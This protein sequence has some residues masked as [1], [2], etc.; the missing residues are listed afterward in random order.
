MLMENIISVIVV[1]YNQQDTI[2]AT[3]DSILQQ[4]CH[5]PVEIV[6]GDDCST[7]ETGKICQQYA[8][9]HPQS[10]RYIRNAKN[11]G[12]VNNYF[13]CLLACRGAYIADCAGDDHWTDCH[14]LEAELTLLEAHPD[15]TLV[16]TNWQYYSADTG[17]MHPSGTAP[18]TARIT[19]GERMI[20]PIL[21]AT[22]R[23][24]IHLCTALYRKAVFMQAYQDDEGLF[25]N[26]NFT[27]ED[28]QI[29]FV[30]ARQGN[31]AYLPQCTLAY[32]LSPHTISNAYDEEKSFRFVYGVTQLLDYIAQ[33]YDIH[34][35]ALQRTLRNKM[36]ALAMHAFRASSP[37][38]IASL[39]QL[40]THHHLPTDLRYHIV[41]AVTSYRWS[42]RCALTL[43][44]LYLKIK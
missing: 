8:R 24:V 2:A 39:Q 38:L 20:I 22:R 32:T 27:C 21:T 30:M 17:T 36:F 16:H 34:D 44:Q 43:R 29:A 13:D 18:F 25:R 11:K 5:L 1:T 4:E 15:V 31:I 9:N 33:H 14:K 35:A 10:I 40:H 42:W 7:D 23:P 3:L 26:S 41:Q 6:I 37:T 28:L 12:V 19:P